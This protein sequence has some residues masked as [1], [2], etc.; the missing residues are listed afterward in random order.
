MNPATL[1]IKGSP[2]DV[3]NRDKSNQEREL[4]GTEVPV[5]SGIRSI[6]DSR[7][8]GEERIKETKDRN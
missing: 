5:V 7:L 8:S 2:S 3:F 6:T 4:T 1:K